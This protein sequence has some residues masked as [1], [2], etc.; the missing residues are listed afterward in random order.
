MLKVQAAA[1][2]LAIIHTSKQT[3][4]HTHTH[5]YIHTHTHTHA[6]LLLFRFGPY[7]HCNPPSNGHGGNLPGNFSCAGMGHGGPP[8]N[9]SSYCACERTN[10]TVG[11][12]R[13]SMQVGTDASLHCHNSLTHRSTLA[14][15]A[16]TVALSFSLFS[17]IVQACSSNSFY[18]SLWTVRLSQFGSFGGFIGAL[19]VLLDGLWFSTPEHGEC[20]GADPVG[21]NGCT[22]RVKSVVKVANASCV[23]SRLCV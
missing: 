1:S 23:Q 8:K 2:I 20:K 21:T 12:Q 19:S 4:R 22:W 5:T 6:H 17:L 3:H 15:S 7:G 18:F 13:V 9:T 11:E 16:V 14:S 10:I